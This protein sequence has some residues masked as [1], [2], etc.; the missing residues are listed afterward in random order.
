LTDP[1]EAGNLSP[2]DFPRREREAAV[3]QTDP[4]TDRGQDPRLE[5][6]ELA[7]LLF[8][9]NPQPAWIFETASLRFV[10]VNS[11]AARCYGYTREE[12]LELTV[13]DICAPEDL[14]ELLAEVWQAVEGPAGMRTVGVRRHRRKDGARLDIEVAWTRVSY[15]QRSAILAVITDVTAQRLAEAALWQ[16]EGH[17]RAVVNRASVILWAIDLQGRIT[18][19]EGRGLAGM[20]LKPGETVGQSIHDLYKDDRRIIELHER[21]LSGEQFSTTVEAGGRFYEAHYTPLRTEGEIVGAF[22]VA[23]DVTARREAERALDEAVQFNREIVSNAA[24]GIVVLDHELRYRVWNRAMEEMTGL[25]AADVLGQPALELFPHLRE[26]GV[27]ALFRRALSGEMVTSFDIHFRIPQN[28]RTGWVSARYGPHRNA[29]G[30]IE[31]VVGL[32]R[33]ITDRRRVEDALRVSEARHR[34]LAESVSDA[35]LSI[36]EAGRIGFVNRTAERLFGYAQT[37]LQGREITML[38]PESLRAR[39]QA[40]LRAYV[41]SGERHIRWEGAELTGRRQDGTEFPI[42]VSFGEFRTDEGRQFVGVIRDLTDRR[43][44]DDALRESEQKFRTIADTLPCGIYIYQDGHFPFANAALTAITGY[45]REELEQTSFWDVIH[46]DSHEEVRQRSS[47]RQAGQPVAQRYEIRILR[48]DGQPRWVDLSDEIIVYG[49]HRAALGTVFDN[50][51]RRQ[52]ELL[53][54]DRSRVIEMVATNQPLPEILGELVELVE[55]QRPEMVASMLL[56]RGGRA[57]QG[58]A[59]ACRKATAAHRGRH[60]DRAGRRLLRHRGVSRPDGHQRGHRA[61][62]G[63]EGVQPAHAGE[64]AAR[65]LVGADLLRDPRG[66][67]DLR[68][69][70]QGAPAADAGGPGAAAGRVGPGRGGHRAA[71]PHRPDRAPGAPRRADGAAQPRAVRGPP[72]NGGHPCASPGAPAG[73][74]VPGRRPVQGDQRLAGTRPGRP[75]PAGGRGAAAGVRARR[76]HRR[77]PGRR[78]V[79]PAAALDRERGGRREGGAQG[80]GGHPPALPPGGTRPLPHR[81]HRHQRLPGRRGHGGRAHQERRQRALP[82][83]GEGTRRGPALRAGHERPG[84]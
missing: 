50:T 27:D 11:A 25:P 60:P 9:S 26:Q 36:D 46:P 5:G 18:L 31:G 30:R 64:R 12:F 16:S 20:G 38:M 55:R 73:G 28:G 61:G 72:G 74:A 68:P 19:S 29:A 32:V 57:V 14:D 42:E 37:E 2:S 21:A 69:L 34:A 79:H 75:A 3:S 6:G 49:G 53:D 77:A 63:V 13:R 47:A 83:Q 23:T 51:D 7:G 80:P 67:R 35:L 44:R 39:H 10:A 1:P 24:E 43:R 56:L 58:A 54:R 22:A 81:Q 82:G 59:R 65:V 52:T 66:A 48:K 4:R 17:L 15:Q 70:L 76:R 84:R 41:E 78:R 62:P 71:R 8:E 40:S 45:T 33:E